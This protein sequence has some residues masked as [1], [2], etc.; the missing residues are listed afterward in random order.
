M[1]RLHIPGLFLNGHYPPSGVEASPKNLKQGTPIPAY[2]VAREAVAVA[3]ATR[4]LSLK[5][6]HSL[7]ASSRVRAAVGGHT[8]L[9]QVRSYVQWQ[10]L[11]L[12]EQSHTA[13]L[14]QFLF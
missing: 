7:F 5:G 8:S 2:V 9:A 6:K 13:T 11:G 1:V 3:L 10:G 4:S 12:S 14:P